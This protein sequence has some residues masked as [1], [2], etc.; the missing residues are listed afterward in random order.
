MHPPYLNTQ[1]YVTKK[2]NLGT[3]LLYA[4]TNPRADNGHLSTP[5]TPPHCFILHHLLLTLLKS[6]KLAFKMSDINFQEVHDLLVD[7]AHEAGG[8]MLAATPSYLSSGTKKNCKFPPMARLPILNSMKPQIWL[9]K[10]TKPLRKWYRH[11]S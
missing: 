3:G 2:L 4:W 9:L 11:V 7:I 8:M 1:L 5:L 10:L 6:N